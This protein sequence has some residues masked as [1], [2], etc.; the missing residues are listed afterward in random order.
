MNHLNVSEVVL[1]YINKPQTDY[2]LLIS[3][4][5][6]SGKTHYW[7]WVVQPK[8]EDLY[9]QQP[10]YLSLYGVSSTNEIAHR[11]FLETYPLFKKINKYSETTKTLINVAGQLGGIRGLGDIKVYNSFLKKAPFYC[12]DDLERANLDIIE[13]LGFINKFVEHEGAKTVIIA[14]ETEI[15]RRDSNSTYVRFKEKMIGK[16]LIFTPVLEE[17]I[18]GLINGFSDQNSYSDYLNRSST[19]NMII[20]NVNRSNY[21]NLRSL[22][23]ALSDF[24]PLYLNIS[25]STQYSSARVYQLLDLLLELTVI[26]CIEIKAGN[27]KEEMIEKI[28]N[29]LFAPQIYQSLMAREILYD[30]ESQ[31]PPSV[32]EYPQIIFLSYCPNAKD[33]L[34]FSKIVARYLFTGSIQYDEFEKECHTIMERYIHDNASD[35]SPK[36]SP[37]SIFLHK[38]WEV[39]DVDFKKIVD[40]V[41]QDLIKGNF[42][43]DIYPLAFDRFEYFITKDLEY[44]KVSK[45]QL[46]ADVIAGSVK[47]FT[48]LSNDEHYLAQIDDKHY[49]PF[50]YSAEKKQNLSD[51]SNKVLLLC[52][53]KFQEILTK[54][55]THNSEKLFKLLPNNFKEFTEQLQQFTLDDIPMYKFIDAE[56]LYQR[57]INLTNKELIEFRDSI[58]RRKQYDNHLITDEYSTLSDLRK[59]IDN[60]VSKQPRTIKTLVLHTV[61]ESLP[62]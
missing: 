48:R 5:W 43:L 26:L 31:S 57:V 59:L 60:Y 6:G 35:D 36:A 32:E 12:F 10:I 3:G 51:D 29:D 44:L 37:I 7:K 8:V 61:M 28:E 25:K 54:R 55:H 11:I 15:L 46:L 22:K 18:R 52:Q 9:K 38:F 50:E 33:A 1:D 56:L 24:Y 39:E 13:V 34:Y 62:K 17:S 20:E 40:S 23:R 47:A 27:F 58:L 30:S 53:E 2:A 41:Y 19:I 49:N 45:D 14:N 4:E 16:T 21:H 42:P